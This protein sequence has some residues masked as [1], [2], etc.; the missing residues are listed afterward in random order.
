MCPP[1]SQQLRSILPQYDYGSKQ[2]KKVK[3]KQ[4]NTTSDVGAF[5]DPDPTKLNF[6]IKLS[7]SFN[8][9]VSI[10]WQTP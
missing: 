9:K 8:I 4:Y 6:L 7:F 2:D 3:R 10:I 5:I 1:P